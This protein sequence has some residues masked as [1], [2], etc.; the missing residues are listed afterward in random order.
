[1]EHRWADLLSS[2]RRFL[3]TCFRMSLRASPSSSNSLASSSSLP[4]APSPV[5]AVSVRRTLTFP[6]RRPQKA[7]PTYRALEP[8]LE[9]DDEDSDDEVIF[10]STASRRNSATAPAKP[11]QPLTTAAAA[12]GPAAGCI[13][14][15]A[16]PPARKPKPALRKPPTLKRALTSPTGSDIDLQRPRLQQASSSTEGSR[17]AAL[18][19][20]PTCKSIRNPG[21]LSRT[22]SQVRLCELASAAGPKSPDLLRALATSDWTPRP[23][24]S[25]PKTSP[26]VEEPPT[27]TAATRDGWF[28]WAG[29]TIGDE[30]E[31]SVWSLLSFGARS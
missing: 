14:L 22:H 18:V 3:G 28:D 2:L 24:L 23:V 19:S 17:M 7:S 9:S 8:Y 13:T 20:G 31:D 16:A 30:D 11:V 25:S 1:M 4:P 6:S 5:A 27:T 29:Y 10:F 26:A 21:A 12:P 15:K